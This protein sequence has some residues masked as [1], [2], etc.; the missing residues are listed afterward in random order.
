MAVWCLFN[1][2]SC[3][4][5]NKQLQELRGCKKDL[6]QEVTLSGTDVRVRRCPVSQVTDVEHARLEAYILFE[7]GYLPNAGGWLDQPVKF[8]EMMLLIDALVGKFQKEKEAWQQ[9]T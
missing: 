7:K 1:D 5:C 8:T 4:K 2:T 9:K 3:H 6:P